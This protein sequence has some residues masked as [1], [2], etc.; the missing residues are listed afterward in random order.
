MNIGIPVEQRPFEFR[1]GLPPAGVEILKHY[2]HTIFVEHDAGVGAGFSDEEFERAGA[3]IVYSPEEVFGRADLLLKIARPLKE[4]IEWLP[5]GSMIAGLLHLASARQDKV[6]LMLK[7]K[8]TAI[9]YEQIE[10][11][12]GTTPVKKPLAEIGGRMTAQIAAHYMQNYKGGKGILLSGVTGVP[13]AEIVIIGAGVAGTAASRTF[14]GLGAHVTVLDMDLKALQR[15][16]ER[17][18]EVVTLIATPSNIARTCAFA[19]VVVGAVLVP[20]ERSPIV[21]TRVMVQSMKPRS[22]IIDMSIDQGGCVETSRPTTHEHCTYIEENIIHYCV[23]NIP[24]AVART[25]THA[26]VNAAM[27]YILDL[28]NKDFETAIRETPALEKAISTHDGKMMH[29][30][31]LNG[32]VGI[33]DGLD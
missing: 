13:P 18:P 8:I 26:F 10:E 15:I 2:G 12:D 19:D 3:R 22:M 31:R 17:F 5:P 4:E 6:D 25:A 23:P 11:A 7:N 9:A 32:P 27:Y 24:A 33:N 28:A 20:G 1:V 14:L 21:V 16:D 30:H 29:M